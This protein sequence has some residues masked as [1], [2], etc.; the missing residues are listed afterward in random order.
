MDCE[1]LPYCNDEFED[2]FDFVQSFQASN[3]QSKQSCIELDFESSSQQQQQGEE[4]LDTVELLFGDSQSSKMQEEPILQTQPVSQ[5]P[6]DTDEDDLDLYFEDC[7]RNPFDDYIEAQ[8]CKQQPFFLTQST[9][10]S[11]QRPQLQSEELDPWGALQQTSDKRLKCEDVQELR[12]LFKHK[13]TSREANTHFALQSIKSA[14]PLNTAI[15]KLDKFFKHYFEHVVG[16]RNLYHFISGL[17]KA[18]KITQHELSAYGG[19]VKVSITQRAGKQLLSKY[20]S[21]LLFL[22]LARR[23]DA[24]HRPRIDEV[25]RYL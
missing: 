16:S 18:F 25:I 4:V 12:E 19:I 24:S 6:T 15:H 21:V 14:A 23:T 7:P 8:K 11:E 3:A 20:L 17:V 5:P 9:Q 2:E 1:F 10:L 13:F 22:V